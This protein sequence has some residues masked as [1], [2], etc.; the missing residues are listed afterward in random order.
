MVAMWPLGRSSTTW[1][2]AD[3]R[4]AID[5]AV[6]YQTA[7]GSSYSS[8]MSWEDVSSF[9][10][11]NF[12]PQKAIFSVGT[13]YVEILNATGVTSDYFAGLIGTPACVIVNRGNEDATIRITD[14][15]ANTLEQVIRS[16]SFLVIPSVTTSVASAT[17]YSSGET[18]ATIEAKFASTSGDLEMII[19]SASA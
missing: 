1:R 3:D 8:A 14:G 13:T 11:S 2:M 5:V 12:S 16:D 18:I 17:P 19:Y 15:N 10:S 9:V 6:K 7:D 4:A